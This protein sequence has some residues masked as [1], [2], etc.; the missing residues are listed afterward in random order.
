MPEKV[1]GII[2]ASDKLHQVQR[3]Y[4]SYDIERFRNRLDYFA[5]QE[6]GNDEE[7]LKGIIDFDAC[8]FTEEDTKLLIQFLKELD[9]VNDG[10]QTAKQAITNIKAKGLEPKGTQKLNEIERQKPKKYIK[11]D[12][13]N[14]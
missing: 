12:K 1:K 14:P 6:T 7:I 13:R 11:Q 5:N 2:L 9:G 8:N 3:D 4:D 10:E